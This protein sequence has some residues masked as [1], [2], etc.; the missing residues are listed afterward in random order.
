MDGSIIIVFY[1]KYSKRCG[2]FFEIIREAQIDYRKICIDNN[3]IR[4]TILNESEKYNIRSVPTV[5]IFYSN[6]VMNKYEEEKAFE[7]AVKQRN[8]VLPPPRQEPLSQPPRPKNYQILD[9]PKETSEPIEVQPV[10]EEDLIGMKRR[11]ETA[12]LFQKGEQVLDDEPRVEERKTQKNENIKN[13]AQL[14]Q[15]ER[16]KEDENLNPN[17]ISKVNYS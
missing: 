16:E 7:W 1:S 10:R 13:L 5:L 3:D 6:G 12:P 4:N 17:A 9:M 2:E 8:A 14:L 11:I 15:A